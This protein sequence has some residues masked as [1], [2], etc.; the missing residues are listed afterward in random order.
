[1]SKMGITKEDFD[2]ITWFSSWAVDG[3]HSS[4]DISSVPDQKMH[5]NTW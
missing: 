3:D 4:D 1:M 5:L 2:A